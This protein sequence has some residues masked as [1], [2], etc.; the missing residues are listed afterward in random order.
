MSLVLGN[1]LLSACSNAQSSAKLILV[2]HYEQDYI[3]CPKPN[4]YQS[5]HTTIMC[6]GQVSY[7]STLL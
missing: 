3:S 2:L 1:A 4:N 6:D 5:L 7:A